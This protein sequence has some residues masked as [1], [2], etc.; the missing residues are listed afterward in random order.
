MPVRLQEV[1][2][3]RAGLLSSV[4]GRSHTCFPRALGETDNNEVITTVGISLMNP[5]QAL[6]MSVSHLNLTAVL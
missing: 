3:Q 6:V 1:L 5:P 2:H 4:E